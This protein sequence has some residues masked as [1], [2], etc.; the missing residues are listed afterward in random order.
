MQAYEISSLAQLRIDGRK[1]D[2]IRS[3]ESRLGFVPHVDGSTYMEHGLNKVLAMVIG[4]HEPKRRGDPSANDE[5][6][7]FLFLSH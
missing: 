6:S 2:E 5:V 7:F 3:I 4:P 1:H